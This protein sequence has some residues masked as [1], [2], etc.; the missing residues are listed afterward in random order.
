MVPPVGCR[1]R[2]RDRG[3]SVKEPLGRTTRHIAPGFFRVIAENAAAREREGRLCWTHAEW[4]SFT[5]A[6][7]DDRAIAGIGY[8][9]KLLGSAL[10]S[11]V[12]LVE[13]MRRDGKAP[14]EMR[15]VFLFQQKALEAQDIASAK[16][17]K[18]MADEIDARAHEAAVQRALKDERVKV[19]A[20]ERARTES[21]Y[22]D[23]RYGRRRIVA[24]DDSPLE[25]R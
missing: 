21:Q 25:I 17:A 9:E 15:R 11:T 24:D 5:E 4:E 13:K 7:R 12:H 3:R 23:D 16:R 1:V 6:A 18:A 20:R 14:D 8:L 10:V 2:T 22:R 19:E